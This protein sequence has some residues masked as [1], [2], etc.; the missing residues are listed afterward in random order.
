M[1]GGLAGEGVHETQHRS[2]IYSHLNSI[3]RPSSTN[4]RARSRPCSRA[5]ARGGPRSPVPSWALDC[6]D[7]DVADSEDEDHASH[8]REKR[9]TE[10]L[11]CIG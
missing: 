4:S 5:S 6:A 9:I 11:C 7:N 1:R 2:Q 10:R 3:S 8:G